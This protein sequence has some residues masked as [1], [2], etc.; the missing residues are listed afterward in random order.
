MGLTQSTDVQ[1]EGT[2]LACVVVLEVEDS[3][4]VDTDDSEKSDEA[5]LNDP[6]D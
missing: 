4:E 2:H 3:L 5:D 6:A 1:P